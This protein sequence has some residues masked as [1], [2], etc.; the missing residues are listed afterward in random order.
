MIFR[1][2]L[3]KHE[4]KI[5][6]GCEWQKE[7]AYSAL[8]GFFTG[9][10]QHSPLGLY[11]LS[12]LEGKPSSSTFREMEPLSVYRAGLWAAAENSLETRKTWESYGQ[13]SACLQK[14]LALLQRRRN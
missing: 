13:S 11:F 12:A 4:G 7:T 2:T 3:S 1:N 10:V 14:Q 6:R 9:I 8:T 5:F